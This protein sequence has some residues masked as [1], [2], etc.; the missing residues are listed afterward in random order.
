MSGVKTKSVLGYIF[1]PRIFPRIRELKGKGFAL[2]SFMMA[3]I[4]GIVRLLPR[5]HPYLLKENFGRYGI[6]HVI[7]EAANN[8][9]IDKKNIDQ[10]FIF[11][12]MLVGIAI[13][14]IQ[15]VLTAYVI[16]IKPVF[17]VSSFNTPQPQNDIAF[18]LMDRVF[19]IPDLF[20]NSAG[21]CTSEQAN[22]P[23]PFHSALH[24]MFQFYSLGL[25]VIGALI[26][27][28]FIVVVVAETATTGT[29]FGQRFQNIWVPVRLITA[30]GLLLPLSHGL[31]SGQYIVLYAAKI[32]SGFATNG[33]IR[34]NDAI[35]A[36]AS[37]QVE[38]PGGDGANVLGERDTLLAL[39]V[40]PSV[41]STLEFMSIVHACSYAHWHMNSR[42]ENQD[43]V[44]LPLPNDDWYIKPYM[45]KTPA[46]FG[47][48]RE[49]V[50]IDNVNFSY[51]DAVTFYN[52]GDIIIHFGEYSDRF[53]NHHGDVKPTCG[54]I[55]IKVSEKVPSLGTD[56][57]T[58]IGAS[59]VQQHYFQMINRIWFGTSPD[60]ARIKDMSQRYMA[61]S[62][63]SRLYNGQPVECEVAQGNADLPDTTGGGTTPECTRI[64]PSISFKQLAIDNYQADLED[65]ILIAWVN[66]NT[67]A[68]EIQTSGAV[69]ERGWAGAGMWYNVIN[70]INGK[71]VDAVINPPNAVQYPEIMEKT[72]KDR[73]AN[74]S[75]PVGLFKFQPTVS[76][77]RKVGMSADE[78]QIARSLS[79]YYVFWNHE[80]K[81]T[82]STNDYGTG[83]FIEDFF[84]NIFGLNGLIAMRG[85]NAATHPLAQ[86]SA[87]GKSLV[88][89]AIANIGAATGIGFSTAALG[90][91][92]EIL[93]SLFQT[94]AFIGLTA[95]FVLFYVL[96]FLPFVYFFFS[97]AA[98]L[99]AIFEA[100]VGAP[101]WALAHLR[102][103]GEGL[104]G[105]AASNGYFL[106]F[107]IFLRPIL[108]VMG[109]ICSMI[110]F[111]AQVRLL[112]FIW[113]I[114]TDNLTGFAGDNEPSIGAFGHELIQR[115]PIDQ[116]FFTIIYAVIVYM[117]ATAS[118]KVI[119]RIPEGILRWMGAGV[120]SFGD[121]RGDA[122]QGLTRYA[123]IGALTIN[124]QVAGGVIKAGQGLGGGL[125]DLLGN[126]GQSGKAP[127]IK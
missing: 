4:Y 83:N 27:L 51:Q 82:S 10:I 124:Q 76:D 5:N 9:V 107:E 55:R 119:D 65:E 94:T 88:D 72:V 40:T 39:P 103:D 11:I 29:P 71:F 46:P 89:S 26:F 47:D 92:Q 57:T 52:M 20:C 60:A 16:V 79:D 17:A 14:C 31:N 101:L 19:G 8:L 34:Y 15:I 85:Q 61:V 110:V 63:P 109:L 48:T 56:G 53:N 3:H 95:G 38:F 97:V 100:M 96:P 102:I 22:I 80:G 28:Y 123:G 75:N 44:D 36:S 30:I 23:T 58:L 104:P 67:E 84:M 70:R 49:R 50:E 116:F 112:N 24:D 127:K 68:T 59:A 125:N 86:L 87:L 42:D 37:G 77:H 121:M 35:V 13:L 1:L 21:V 69:T 98:W 62:L 41:A 12:I 106:I 99:K 43:A 2:I 45:T 93:S 114:V 115:T 91:K 54:S 74:D 108:T 120:Q 122:T 18:I 117:M 32:G 118:F 6:R 126:L 111:T 81:D 64:L 90:M 113:T 73:M 33:W 105:D 66:Y 25:L 7:G 78:F